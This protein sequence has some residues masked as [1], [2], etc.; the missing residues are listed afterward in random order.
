MKDAPLP[1][2]RGPVVFVVVQVSPF[3]FEHENLEKHGEF[4]DPSN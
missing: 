4:T 3:G 1:L 2:R